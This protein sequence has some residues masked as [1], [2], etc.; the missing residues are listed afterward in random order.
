MD[1]IIKLITVTTG[2]LERPQQEA[3]T[4]YL[5]MPLPTLLK[6]FRIS[7]IPSRLLVVRGT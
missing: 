3:V 7:K 5:K 2:D 6:R 1:L 4:V